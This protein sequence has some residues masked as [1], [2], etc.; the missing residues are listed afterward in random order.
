MS[1]LFRLMQTIGGAGTSGGGGVLLADRGV[2]DSNGGSASASYRLTSTGDIEQINT[3]FGVRDI[4]DWI[5]PKSGAPGTYEV[6][7]DLASGS[8]P[9]SSGTLGSWLALTS[10]RTWTLQSSDVGSH[11]AQIV[12][13]I[14]QGSTVL[15]SATISFFLEVF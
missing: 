3:L 9:I 15:T 5:S 4:G 8:R 2:F 12:V 13:Q 6:R 14:R 11:E 10:S 1:L 7:A